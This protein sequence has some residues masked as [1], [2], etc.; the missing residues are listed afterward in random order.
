MKTVAEGLFPQTDQ[1]FPFR[2]FSM[3]PPDSRY[4]LLT[5][6]IWDIMFR[7]K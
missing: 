3:T 5:Y 1:R 6:S 7:E 2:E 4:L